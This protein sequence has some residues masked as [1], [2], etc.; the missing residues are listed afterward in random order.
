MA[1]VGHDLLDGILHA[2]EF[3]KGGIA[4]NDAV[5]EQTG[6]AGILRRIDHV[7]LA[8]GLQQTLCRI[9]IGAAILAAEGEKCLQRELFIL[10][11]FIALAILVKY[12]HSDARPF[13]STG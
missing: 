1:Q 13:F 11:R 9:G 6:E 4:G 10:G 12:V 3:G 5:G 2:I 7:G 8:D